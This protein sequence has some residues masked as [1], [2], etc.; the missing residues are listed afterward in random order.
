MSMI[1]SYAQVRL[2]RPAHPLGGRMT[3]PRPLIQVAMVGPLASW[4][5]LCLLDTGADDTVFPDSVAAIIGVDLTN[6]PTGEASGVGLVSTPLRY[7][8]V[9]LRVT[10]GREFCEWPAWVGFTAAP[11]RRPLLG[12]AGCLQFFDANCRGGREEV[13]LVANSLYPVALACSSRDLPGHSAPATQLP[14]PPN[15]PGGSPQYRRHS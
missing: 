2:R 5:D 15:Q 6:A 4:A 7:A 14:R 13:E 9:I 10:D 8:Q 1:F 3:R 12:F 11:L